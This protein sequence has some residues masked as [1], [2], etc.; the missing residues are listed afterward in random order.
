VKGNLKGNF[1][2]FN[3]STPS[4]ALFELLFSGGCLIRT[5]RR[6]KLSD[7]HFEKM[8]LLRYIQQ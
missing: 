4:S 7:V 2:K 1:L 3:A 5:P 8:L 6:N